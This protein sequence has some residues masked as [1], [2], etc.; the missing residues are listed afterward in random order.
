[1][2]SAAAGRDPAGSTEGNAKQGRGTRATEA[3]RR[4]Q[5]GASGRRTGR[6][7]AE[8]A[9]AREGAGDHQH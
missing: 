1:M 6:R 3:A 8:G 9:G 4:T 7:A 2:P 5:R